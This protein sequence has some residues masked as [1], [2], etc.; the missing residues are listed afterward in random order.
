MTDKQLI[1][2]TGAKIKI[3]RKQQKLTQLDLSVKAD[4]PENSLQR[5]ETGRINATVSTLLKISTALNIEFFE[6][7]VFE[8]DV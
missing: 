5:I 8:N 7:F 4:I 2:K 1:K 3:L 6:L